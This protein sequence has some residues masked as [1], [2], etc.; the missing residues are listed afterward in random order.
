[1]RWL[2]ARRVVSLALLAAPVAADPWSTRAPLLEAVQEVAVAELAGKVYV[3]GGLQGTTILNRVEVWDPVSD[4]W[5]FAATLPI[6]LHHTTATAAAGKLYVIGGWPNFFG[7]PTARTFAYDRARTPGRR[8]R[9]C[10][11]R[12]AHPR[13]R[14]WAE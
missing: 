5:S 4:S 7:A 14:P 11:L 12:A 10:R 8:R 1:M 3:V 9:R 13:R 6:P 2:L